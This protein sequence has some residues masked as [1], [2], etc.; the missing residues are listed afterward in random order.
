MVLY[1]STRYRTCVRSFWKR[2]QENWSIELETQWKCRCSGHS[3]SF[4]PTFCPVVPPLLFSRTIFSGVLSSC[5]QRWLRG[6]GR[7]G[8]WVDVGP[9]F[10]GV[11]S[12]R[13]KGTDETSFLSRRGSW[14]VTQ[15][16]DTTVTGP[17]ESIR[18]SV[19]DLIFPR[20]PR[21]LTSC[22]EHEYLHSDTHTRAY[23]FSTVSPGLWRPESSL[24]NVPTEN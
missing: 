18:E 2:G 16:P 15:L 19:T 4:V 12:P 22:R 5:P 9:L 8:S 23:L 20:S 24:T 6:L 3:L 1:K 7:W 13:T 17:G 21:S 14:S 11:L 10:S